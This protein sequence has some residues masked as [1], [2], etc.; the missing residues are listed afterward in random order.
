MAFKMKGFSPYKQRD[1]D[2]EKMTTEQA[3]KHRANILKYNKDKSKS[4]TVMQKNKIKS[5]LNK[6]NPSDPEAKLLRDMLNLPKN[7]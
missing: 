2:S 5:Q 6:M 4:L 3:A 7:K 1:D